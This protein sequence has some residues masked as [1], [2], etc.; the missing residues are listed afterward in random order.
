MRAS[1]TTVSVIA[2][3]LLATVLLVGAASSATAT[4]VVSEGRESTSAAPSFSAPPSD[5]QQ[6]QPTNNTTA[7][8]TASQTLI[9]DSDVYLVDYWK[10]DGVLYVQLYSEHSTTI[11]LSA[12]PASSAEVA[13]GYIEE[14]QIP[15][16][17]LTTLSITAP[18]DTASI[19][20]SD[21]RRN[22]RYTQLDVAGPGFLPEQFYGSDVLT[23]GIF[24]SLLTGAAVLVGVYKWRY[25][26]DDQG[27]EQVA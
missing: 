14:T 6:V 11:T 2:T 16:Q 17:Q 20:S 5:T 8:Y 10:S 19:S 22:G 27:G 23:A 26:R 18:A 12:P 9:G 3:V 13:G 7:N 24:A 21:S 25:E 4:P 15:R 1:R